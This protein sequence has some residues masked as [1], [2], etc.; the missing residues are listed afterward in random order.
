MA[1]ILGVVAS[2]IA[3][4][5]LAAEL[6]KGVKALHTFLKDTKDA[7]ANLQDVAEELETIAEML[8]MLESTMTSSA[9]ASA[10]VALFQK[11]HSRCVKATAEVNAVVAGLQKGLSGESKLRRKWSSVQAALKKGDVENFQRKLE[12]AKSMMNTAISNLIL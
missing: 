10:P 6:L 7:P 3:V 4:G 12:S 8:S 11:C 9:S 5:Q 1:E 2:G